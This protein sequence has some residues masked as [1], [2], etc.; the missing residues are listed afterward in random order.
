MAENE[1]Q[2]V[3]GNMITITVTILQNGSYG[4]PVQYQRIFFFDQT[5]NILLGSVLSNQSGVA[6]LD[7]E[8]PL[9]HTIGVTVINATFY[10]NE[11][12]SL[13]PSFQRVSLTI[14]SQTHIEIDHISE[15]LTLGDV[16]SFNI[17]LVDD[18]NTSIVNAELAVFKDTT[19][20][21][22]GITNLSGQINFY[23]TVDDR[24]SLGTNTLRIQYS[25]SDYYTQSILEETITV[26]SPILITAE[27]PEIAEIESV[28]AVQITITDILNRHI[29]DSTFSVFDTTSDQRFSGPVED[30]TINFQYLLQGPAGTH[31]LVI[32]VTENPYISNNSLTT[33]FTAWSHP[34]VILINTG[35][36]HYASPNQELTF[37]VWL[38][39][40]QENC[41]LRHLQL[42]IDSE[43]HTSSITDINGLA[44]LT[45]SAPAIE[46]QYNISIVYYGNASQYELGTKYD[47]HLVVTQVMPIRI[48]LDSYEVIAALNELSLRLTV[49]GLNGS[50]LKG[51]T[52]NFNWLSLDSTGES[53]DNGLI[54]LHLTVPTVSGDYALYYESESTNSIASTI[55]SIM[56]EI[57]INDIL[58]T[59]G[60]GITGMIL[61]LAA[62]IGIVTVPIVRRRYLI[63]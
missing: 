10:G 8:I 41:S 5:N 46:A 26:S 25:G 33:N 42:F 19:L 27:F 47:Y 32:E 2:V 29:P 55:G 31:T 7:W 39:D 18:S 54:I 63:G 20:L 13:A 43:S 34:E 22:T 48:D 4:S 9:S 21:A 17:L 45:F 11:S 23:T 14:L 24:F 40:W 6:S 35:V 12:L 51:V 44:S 52:V 59:E 37:E 53:L 56:I 50:F 15:I 36:N 49:Q 58:T 16:L 30:K 28:L 60:I 3:R 1:I 57:T 38:I 62:S 61:V